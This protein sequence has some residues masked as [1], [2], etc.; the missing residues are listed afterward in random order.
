MIRKCYILF[1]FILSFSFNNYFSIFGVGEKIN[2]FDAG[3]IA[4]GNAKFFTINSNE[5][6]HN[7]SS[8]FIQSEFVHFYF[9]TQFDYFSSNKLGVMQKINNIALYAPI[10][11][12]NVISFQ[13]KPYIH[14][15]FEVSSNVNY[16]YSDKDSIGYYYE[17]LSNGGV[18]SAIIS[19]STF[20]SHN[21]S[22]GIDYYRFFG[23]QI[24][25]EFIYLIQDDDTTINKQLIL[26][27]TFNGNKLNL[28]YR[29]SYGRVQLAGNTGY[30]IVFK[31][32]NLIK[33]DTDVVLL[34]NFGFGL[35]YKISQFRKL[36]FEYSYIPY[37]NYNVSDDLFIFEDYEMN[38]FNLGYSIKTIFPNYS[39]IN[40]L[41]Y[42]F[43]LFVDKV[44]NMSNFLNFG[45][46]CG[47]SLDFLDSKHI[48]NFTIKAGMIINN[49]GILSY[50]FNPLYS[51]KYVQFLVSFDTGDQ[52][53]RKKG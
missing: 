11:K 48:I 10:T 19:L 32:N 2:N 21:L 33:N 53:F 52:W 15:N 45:S 36:I 25:N 35:Q 27:N 5:L 23:K 22:L 37:Y 50:K 7:S 20:F 28:D 40:T 51:Q 29:F 18:S 14:S 24:K 31:I 4:L 16:I 39:N 43:G 6:S 30:K 3:S 47:F 38:Q 13:L 34:D 8:S 41:S 26:V 49:Q 44:T 12:R 9:H 17:L 42:G 46:T 1:L